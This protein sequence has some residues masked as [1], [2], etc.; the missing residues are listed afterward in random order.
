MKYRTEFWGCLIIASIWSSVDNNTNFLI[1]IILAI[2]ILIISLIDVYRMR[3]L[4][5]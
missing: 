5:V 1:W 3:K 2:L 4:D